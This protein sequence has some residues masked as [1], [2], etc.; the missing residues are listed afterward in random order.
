MDYERGKSALF[1]SIEKKRGER[2]GWR[3]RERQR[4]RERDRDSL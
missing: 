4:G 2:E 3:Q 1:F